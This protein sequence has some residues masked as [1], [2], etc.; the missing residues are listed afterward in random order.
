M[1]M[2]IHMT[3][4][5]LGNDG[6][7]A[8]VSLSESSRASG[9]SPCPDPWD[10]KTTFHQFVGIEVVTSRHM[11]RSA[12]LLHPLHY[13]ISEVVVPWIIADVERSS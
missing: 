4:V 3:G 9:G 1:E 7:P 12:L 6:L 5:R 11:G 13:L 10:R 2:G 8:A